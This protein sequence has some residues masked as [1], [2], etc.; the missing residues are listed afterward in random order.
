LNVIANTEDD[1]D[2]DG[3]G[4]DAMDADPSDTKVCI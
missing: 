4:M 2:G 3:D 1:G